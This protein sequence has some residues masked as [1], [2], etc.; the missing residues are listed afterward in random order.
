MK[1]TIKAMVGK[2]LIIFVSFGFIA[3]GLSHTVN[4]T[5]AAGFEAGRIIDDFVFTNS[6]AMNAN[7]IQTFLN[8]KVT[9]CDTNGTKP[10][11]DFGRSDLTHAQYAALR[12]W[13]A[14]PYPCL[15]DYSENG[16]S[17]AQIIYNVAQTYQLNPQVLIVLLQ[18]EQGL[19][20]DT[21]PLPVQY[22]SATGYGCPDTAAC[23]SAYYGLTAQLNWAGTMFHAIVTNNQIWS[24]PY[25]S[26]TVWSTPYILGNNFIYYS[27]NTDC[28]GGAVNIQ[29]RATQALYNYTPYQPNQAA[30][31]AGYGAGDSCS[32]HGNR[33]FYLYFN[34]WFGST[35]ADQNW[36]W[37]PTSQNT[38]LES[39]YTQIML[40]NPSIAPGQKIYA[41]FKAQNTGNT[42]WDNMTR[43]TTDNP[44]GR[45]SLFYD[46]SWL[47]DNRPAY[48]QEQNV[49]P[50]D[51]GTFRFV[52][53]APS[54][55]GLGT[56]TECFNLVQDGVTLFNSKKQCFRISV[57]RPVAGR[58]QD[59]LSM[60]SG[61]T[62]TKGQ[63]LMSPDADSVLIMQDDGNLELYCNFKL[64]WSTNTSGHPDA[65]LKFEVDG[66]LV[67][68]TKDGS[69][70]W[71][72]ST[73]GSNANSLVLQIDRNLVLYKPGGVPV[74]SSETNIPQDMRDTVTSSINGF[75]L[76]Y[77]M[78]RIETPDRTRFLIL[79][80]DGNLVLY[81][82]SGRK[83]I[84]S[85]VTNGKQVKFL[86]MQ[87]DGNLV[88][89]SPTMQ[90]LWA[91]G[92][93]R[94]GVSQLMLQDD[95]NLV[96]YR[97]DG[98]PTWATYTVNR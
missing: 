11:T 8:S 84:W 3:I 59:Y 15:K 41:E 2:L 70:L 26:G 31:N 72:T 47:S 50:G 29:N 71:S 64:V 36:S 33:N 73:S 40:P 88:L 39:N 49:A 43:L 95:S 53:N 37:Q 42:T 75:G 24:N 32:S 85:S 5:S 63:Y 28:G 51:T 21:W 94:N 14:P 19:I 69:A 93:D 55:M 27:P 52:I 68:Y 38:Y 58:N 97:N 25:R 9:S 82:D 86:A 17:A 65:Y 45:N 89:Y 62:L 83:A 44:P 18:K 80:T 35:R 79:Q 66:N 96:V 78:Q 61:K 81:S 16:L 76:M 6:G 30:L 98:F 77:P 20:T 1:N 22:R 7:Q 12:G 92:T 34:D 48:L 91:S 54:T 46:Q 87:S 74:W 90:P 10:A 23:D 4:A 60:S 13:D 67:V 57:T 56:Y